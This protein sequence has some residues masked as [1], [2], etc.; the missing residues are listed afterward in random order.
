MFSDLF[1]PQ[2][3]EFSFLLHTPS[4]S[5]PFP[6]EMKTRQGS[7]KQENI[8]TGMQDTC[9]PVRAHRHAHTRSSTPSPALQE[10]QAAS[11]VTR[12]LTRVGWNAGDVSTDQD[13][14][15]FG[16]WGRSLSFPEPAS[17]SARDPP[18]G[19]AAMTRTGLYEVAPLSVALSGL[20]EKGS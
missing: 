13:P 3:A 18:G 7:G 4:H 20:S 17:G 10:P 14:S 1:F 2:P 15:I 12:D 16:S 8:H 5:T 11:R 9:V 6:E 19:A